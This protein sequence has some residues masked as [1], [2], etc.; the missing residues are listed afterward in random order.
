MTRAVVAFV[1][2]TY[3]LSVSLGLL[4]GLTGG[5]HSPLIGVG[6][7]SMFEPAIAVM[8]VQLTMRAPVSLRWDRLPLRYLAVALLL[9]PVVMHLAMLAATALLGDGSLPWQEW[10]TPQTDGLY[11]APA[12]RGWGALT[13]PGLIAHIA[14]N[15]SV[16]LVVVSA[17]AIFE[18]VG[19]RAW[20]L[21]RLVSTMGPRRAV[22][23]TSVIWA[24]WHVPFILSGILHADG[25]SP[26]RLAMIAPVG[27]MG[28][29][30]VLG[31]L[32][33]RTES[34]WIVALAHGAMNNWGQYAF[35]YMQDFVDIDPGLVLS[36]GSLALLVLGSLLIAFGVPSLPR[37]TVPVPPA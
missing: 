23:S 29:G 34:I 18:E 30:L 20:L 12:S 17:L 4:I 9:I 14:I 3:V 21:P 13:L 31:W 19:W 6:L 25:I 27:T 26:A 7:V 1:A 32:W 28:A 33:L 36:A 16:G 5:A 15:A 22:V 2:L 35:K 8:I 10:L 37:G 11:H 24:A